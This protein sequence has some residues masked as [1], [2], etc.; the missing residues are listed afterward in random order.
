MDST[1]SFGYWVRRRRRAL[2]LTQD[3]LARQVGCTVS[4]IKKIE[5]DERRPS[6]QLATRLAEYLAIPPADHDRFLQAARSELAVDRLD[7]GMPPIETPSADVSHLSRPAN[8]LPTGTVTFLFTD[9]AG[10][11]SL[12]EQH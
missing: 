1:Y 4:M 9:I 2:D 7:L 3:D 12:W 11:T 8:A 5:A 10:S 6:R